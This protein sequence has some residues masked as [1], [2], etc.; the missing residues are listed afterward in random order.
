MLKRILAIIA[1]MSAP[2]AFAAV[3]DVNQATEAQLDSVK[4][5]G[6]GTSRMIL[7]ERKKAEF[8]DWADLI[9]RVK[10]IADSR[11]VRLSAEGLRVN[12]RLYKP[13]ADSK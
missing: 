6:P 7:D 9:A 3:V 4:G 5:I 2:L 11:A 1:L 8:K 12:G 13:A 10:G